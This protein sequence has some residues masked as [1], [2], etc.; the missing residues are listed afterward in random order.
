MSSGSIVATDKLLQKI[1]VELNLKLPKPGVSALGFGVFGSSGIGNRRICT[2]PLL[3]RAAFWRKA[4]GLK[5]LINL[6]NETL[7]N[8]EEIT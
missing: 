3:D 4:V 5:D 8:I 1:A 6:W 2:S 7:Q